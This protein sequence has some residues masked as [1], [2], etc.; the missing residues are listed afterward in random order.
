MNCSKMKMGMSAD[1]IL[2]IYH[3]NAKAFHNHY[4]DLQ[5]LCETLKDPNYRMEEEGISLFNKFVPMLAHRVDNME[6][7]V[8]LMNGEEFYMQTKVDGERIVMHRKG[9][10]YKWFSRKQT[11]YTKDYGA[12]KNEGCLAKY[13]HETF[14]ERVTSI[15]LDGEMCYYDAD[16]EILGKFGNLKTAIKEAKEQG[17]NSRKH[18]YYIVFDILYLNGR[19]ISTSPLKDRLKLLNQVISPKS[20]HHEILT[21]TIGRTPADLIECLDQHMVN[22]EEGL[23]IKLPSSHYEAA[24]RPKTWLKV[25]PDYFQNLS[26]DLDVLVVAAHFGQGRRGGKFASFMLGVIDDRVKTTPPTVL[27]FGKFGTGFKMED[28]PKFVPSDTKHLKQYSARTCPSWFVHP[29]NSKEKPDFLIVPEHGVVVTVKGAEIVKSEVYGSGHTVRFPRFVRFREDKSWEEAM[30]Y[31]QLLEYLQKNKG[32]MQSVRNINPEEVRKKRK[33]EVGSVGVKSRKVAMVDTSMLPTDV[34]GVRKLD[35]LFEGKEICI[36]PNVEDEYDKMELE[37]EVVKHGGKFVQNPTGNTFVVIAD[38]QTMKVTN[39]IKSGNMDIVRSKWLFSCI[40]N[41]ELLPLNPR[42]MI[43][44]TPTT[45]EYF[46]KI[47]DKYSDSYTDDLTESSLREIFAS[48]PTP[49]FIPTPIPK[50]LAPYAFTFP[51]QTWT[52]NLSL[53]TKVVSERYFSTMRH[54]KSIFRSVDFVVYLDAVH[55]V[56]VVENLFPTYTP[57][58]SEK[59]LRNVEEFFK[60]VSEKKS[61][62]VPEKLDCENDLYLLSLKLKVWSGATVVSAWSPAVTHVVLRKGRDKCVKAK[63]DVCWCFKCRR[64]L[65][66]GAWTKFP[67]RYSGEYNFKVV[68]ED[69]LEKCI[70]GGTVVEEF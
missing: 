11:D 65:F 40:K 60:V 34:S 45:K 69:W 39:L 31:S 70:E 27:T 44:A 18:P 3:P 35:E 17:Q 37:R 50:H 64:E 46:K 21:H 63:G 56:P 1:S 52:S 5:K 16:D 36:F 30:S 33:R 32:K 23:V 51:K 48:M 66:V 7:I 2:D 41:G 47:T 53:P 4:G 58:N 59:D 55:P 57:E 19:C 6:E 68:G 54:P 38:R 15:I 28:I 8:K 61:G 12:T 67:G 24:T 42:Y 22:Q 14:H 9:D 13:I 43:F 49:K 20:T 62:Y 26:D 25:K 29:L 10:E